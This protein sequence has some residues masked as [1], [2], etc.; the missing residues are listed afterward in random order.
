VVIINA[1][2]V[3]FQVFVKN[4]S[5][6]LFVSMLLSTPSSNITASVECSLVNLMVEFVFEVPNFLN[7]TIIASEKCG[8][9]VIFDIFPSYYDSLILSNYFM[10]NWWSFSFS[11]VFL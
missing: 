2:H 1:T 6:N 8:N 9:C 3:T 11:K 10:E 7:Y 4:A 5:K